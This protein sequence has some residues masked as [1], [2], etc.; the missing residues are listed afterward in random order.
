VRPRR[1][2]SDALHIDPV[3]SRQTNA[4]PLITTVVTFAA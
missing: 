4:H 2:G 3:S 1:F